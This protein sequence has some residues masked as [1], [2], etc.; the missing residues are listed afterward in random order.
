MK[1]KYL[2]DGAVQVRTEFLNLIA[3]WK[4]FYVIDWACFEKN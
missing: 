1:N 2:V 3:D 4:V